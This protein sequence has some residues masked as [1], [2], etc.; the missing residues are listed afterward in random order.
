MSSSS[1]IFMFAG[2][3]SGDQLGADLCHALKKQ[4]SL[5][6]ISGVAGPQM[7]TA[8]VQPVL[9]MEDFAVMGFSDVLLALPRLFFKRN[10]I[11]KW[12]LHNRPDT[13]VLIDYIEFN[14][15][16]AKTLRSKGYKGKIVQYV[17]PTVWAWRAGRADTLAM[18]Y[19]LLLTTYPFEA[20][21]Y[22]HTSLPLRY[23]GNPTKE[24]INSLVYRSNWKEELNLVDTDP[25]VALFPGSRK[26]EID[27]N[28]PKQ[29]AVAEQLVRQ[30]PN[31]RFAL[32]YAN[33]RLLDKIM[34]HVREST[35]NLGQ[36]LFL[37]PGEYSQELMQ[38]SVAALAKS[39]TVTLELALHDCPTVVMYELSWIN[40]FIA[41]YL[42]RLNMSHYCIVNILATRTLF[43]EFYE[44]NLCVNDIA[45]AL[46]AFIS[47]QKAR[48]QCIAGCHAIAQLLG[49]HN[50]A[51]NAAQAILERGL[52]CK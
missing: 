3:P 52:Q 40:R 34:K 28:L 45:N 36:D 5:L 7:R 33:E 26:G 19:D 18:H 37:I 31:L 13:V 14:L 10:A 21:Y 12:I 23:V 44:R 30:H 29:L 8:G 6:E 9:E 35:L 15:H 2:E 24:R 16:L 50:A 46:E 32:S 20:K 1:K 41:K 42:I 39:G 48:Q 22:S 38:A 49:N 27:L 43:P 11:V 25:L 47:D 4:N 17:S 51:A